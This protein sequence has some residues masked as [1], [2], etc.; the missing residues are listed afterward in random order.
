VGP[1]EAALTHLE[2]PAAADARGALVFFHGFY[3]VPEDFVP[4]MDKIDPARRLHAYLPRGPWP[5]SEG[6]TS[7]LNPD[8]TKES[9]T[10]LEPVWQWLDSIP[11][12]P[13]NT[14]F[15]GWSQGAKVAYAAGLGRRPR[16]AAVVALGGRLPDPGEL[17]LGGGLPPVLIGHG[18]EDDSVPVEHARHARTVLAAAGAEVVYLE[19]QVG[20]LIDPSVIPRVRE[21]LTRTLP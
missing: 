6:R 11:F 7:W 18:S 13:E 15:A 12:Y 8:H 10:D 1:E 16:P 4:F 14:A 17:D 9:P 19:T 21:F 20:H 3:G 2:R 5:M